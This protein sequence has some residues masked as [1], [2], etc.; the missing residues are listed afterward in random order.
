MEKK[1][2]TMR[3][4]DDELRLIKSTFAENFDLL[5]ALRKHFLQL[6]T[7]DEEKKALEEFKGNKGLM[8]LMHKCWL[9]TLDGD[10]PINQVVDLWMTLNI[11]PLTPETAQPHIEARGVVINYLTQQLSLLNGENVLD[12]ISLSDSVD[13]SHPKI[14]RNLTARNT[15]IMHTEQ[16][17][18][19]LNTLAGFKEET[20]EE[21]LERLQK[22]SS[23]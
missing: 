16:Q 5:K 4:S 12:Q 19:Q 13:T 7:T 11:Q 2:Q 10:A 20:P 18:N 23:K 9:P 22:S 21:T 6:Q 17:L 15:I 8:S 3:F 1:Q 14:Y